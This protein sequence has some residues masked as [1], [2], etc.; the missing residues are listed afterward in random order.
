M[1]RKDREVLESYTNLEFHLLLQWFWGCRR[2]GPWTEWPTPVPGV[3][4]LGAGHAGC[5]SC[6]KLC[7]LLLKFTFGGRTLC[8]GKMCLSS[9]VRVDV[10]KVSPADSTNFQG[11]LV[12]CHHH[13]GCKSVTEWLKLYKTLVIRS[14]QVTYIEVALAL[15]WEVSSAV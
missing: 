11:S 12:T 5:A 14:F 13:W 9:E 15:K 7:S 4:G 6:Q 8:T 3:P 10:A 2:L 1:P